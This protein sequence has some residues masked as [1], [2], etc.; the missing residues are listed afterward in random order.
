MVWFQQPSSDPLAPT[1]VPWAETVLA[2]GSYAPDVFFDHADLNGDGLWEIA[3]TTYFSGQGLAVLYTDAGNS[4]PAR[5]TNASGVSRVAVDPSI[6]TSFGLS[7]VD[8][9][10]D[11]KVDVLVTNHVDNTSLA[12]VYA[13]ETPA[14]GNLSD[15]SQWVRHTLATG[16]A[17]VLPLPG[18]AAPGKAQPFFPCTGSNTT[19][20]ASSSVLRKPWIVVSGDGEYH[21]YLLVPNNDADPSDWTY[22]R[23]LLWNCAGTVGEMAVAD[24]DGDGA[25]EIFLP[26]YDTSQLN[27]FTYQGLC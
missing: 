8:L 2:N 23:S 1:S 16:F 9:N 13:Y 3:Y 27:A 5:W 4:G 12:G 10:G 25:A 22:T 15:P 24:V 18:Q 26:C 11:G 21:A 6:G 7:I 19:S 20:T 14:N 17:V